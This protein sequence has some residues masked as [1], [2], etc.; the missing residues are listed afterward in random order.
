M[1][2]RQLVVRQRHLDR[3]GLTWNTA[4]QTAL[5]ELDNHLVN[6]GGRDL[7]EPLEVGLGG[8]SSVQQRVRGD[9]RQVLPLSFGESRGRA[10][11]HGSADLIQDFH[12]HTL[13]RDPDARG[14]TAA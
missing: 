12:E 3:A 1:K 6:S 10:T 2:P 8:R 4:D 13:S 7:E 11:G 5:L 9:E 14:T